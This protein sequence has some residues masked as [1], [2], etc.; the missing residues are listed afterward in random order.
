MVK[1]FSDCCL[2]RHCCALL[3]FLESRNWLVALLLCTVL[4]FLNSNFLK[5]VLLFIPLGD[6]MCEF[7]LN[8]HFNLDR[9]LN[10]RW[11]GSLGLAAL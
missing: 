4:A 2:N 10:R 3:F 6:L 7:Y 1:H 8:V 5:Y 9:H 11:P